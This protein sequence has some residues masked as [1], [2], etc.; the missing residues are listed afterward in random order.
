MLRKQWE[1]LRFSGW[2]T[3]GSK[4]TIKLWSKE[5]LERAVSASI[6]SHLGLL[7]HKV[8]RFTILSDPEHGPRLHIYQPIRATEDLHILCDFDFLQK[9]ALGSP[10]SSNTATTKT[11]SPGVSC[12]LF[13]TSLCLFEH[14]P[15]FTTTLKAMIIRKW[16]LLSR[17]PEP[18]SIV[19]FFYRVHAISSAYKS[20]LQAE[21]VKMNL[22][23][24]DAVGA[25]GMIAHQSTDISLAQGSSYMSSPVG[26]R[27]AA[28]NT[29][30]Y[31][32]MI[33]GPLC[34]QKCTTSAKDNLRWPASPSYAKANMIRGDPTELRRTAFSSNSNG[35]YADIMRNTDQTWQQ[36]YIKNSTSALLEVEVL[37]SLRQYFPVET[38]QIVLAVDEHKRDIFFKRFQGETLN[39]VRLRYYHGQSP[40]SD[41]LEELYYRSDEWFIDLDLRRASD[42]LAAYQ[43]SFRH[44]MSPINCSEQ[45]IHTLYHKRLQN[46]RR[47]QEFYGTC[48][49]SFL[50]GA[51]NSNVSLENFLDIPISI[52]GQSHGTLRYHLDRA[53]HILDPE[54]PAGLQSLPCAFGFG[55]GHGGNVLVSLDMSP[56]SLLYIDYEVTG[57]HTPFLD[58]AKPIYLDGFFDAMYADL[59][60]DDILHKDDSGSIWVDW[61]IGKDCI[62]IDY[63]LALEPLWKTLAGI[64]LEYVLRPILEMLEQIA[65]SQ[66]DTAEETLAC[67]L[68]CCAL[69]SRDYST[70]SDVFYLNLAIGVR[71]AT[72]MRVVFSECFGWSNWPQSVL[73]ERGSLPRAAPEPEN[74]QLISFSGKKRT[75]HGSRAEPIRGT[76]HRPFHRAS[77]ILVASLLSDAMEERNKGIFFYWKIHRSLDFETVVLKREDDT[78][79]LHNR[80]STRAGEGAA[81]ISQRIH[82]VRKEAMRV[83]L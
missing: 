41:H 58:L 24:S 25:T 2:T 61:K 30:G 35:R 7:S 66:R 69:L 42:V 28:E 27:R 82:H 62:S 52:N 48:S 44:K 59:L 60:Y 23:A 49:P 53:T 11:V 22:E 56:P 64:K 54:R 72:E 57:F 4:R 15:G 51:S 78:I 34:P 50:E 32:D 14:E 81:M 36:V 18:R 29:K 65:P 9:T 20:K 68:F 46:H 1:I 55:D 79:A 73:Q 47:F 77:G 40:V 10:E 31:R 26:A 71:L 39:E 16:Q 3:E 63:G 37:Q 45:N 17:A 38:I 67:G 75:L 70:R 33:L 5:S 43:R 74:Q 6:S 21:M 80:F 83:R 8:R 19:P 13:L 12:D 76:A